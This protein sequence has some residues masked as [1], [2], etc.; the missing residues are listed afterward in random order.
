MKVRNIL[1]RD[2]VEDQEAE[3]L[4]VE[5]SVAA[6]AASAAEAA[7]EEVITITTDPQGDLSSD[8]TDPTDITVADFLAACSELLCCQSLLL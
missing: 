7:L 8:F 3:A 6:D 2:L 5:A 1:C 4:A